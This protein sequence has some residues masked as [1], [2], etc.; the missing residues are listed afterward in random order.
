MN[1]LNIQF[2]C[3]EIDTTAYDQSLK[4]SLERIHDNHLDT[5]MR[6]F[7]LFGVIIDENLTFNKHASNLCAKLSR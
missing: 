1:G 3:N 2:D 4:F 6:S 7:K 5:K